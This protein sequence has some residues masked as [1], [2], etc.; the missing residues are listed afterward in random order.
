MALVDAGK[1]S[2]RDAYLKAASKQRFEGLLQDA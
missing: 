2:A 1:I